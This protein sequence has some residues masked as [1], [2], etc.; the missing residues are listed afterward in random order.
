MSEN[1]ILALIPDP[2]VCFADAD[3]RQR[4]SF[5]LEGSSGLI[6]LDWLTSG[7]MARGERWVFKRYLSR[8][9][10]YVEGEHV[11][12]DPI[13]LE[14]SENWGELN[15]DSFE[16]IGTLCLFGG[17][18][19]FERTQLKEEICD[20]FPVARKAFCRPHSGVIC[21]LSPVRH[22][23]ILRVAGMTTEATS[24]F[25]KERLHFL[26]DILGEDPWSR[27]W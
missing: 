17:A 2:V 25:F 24:S 27:K 23:L 19:E 3:Y 7:R 13:L 5:H 21:A 14:P 8:N 11:L 26:E 18:L 15:A 12:A 22:G 16:C 9:D 20:L 1:A 4:Q 6:L 10:V